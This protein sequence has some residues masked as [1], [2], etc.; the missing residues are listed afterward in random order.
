M[1][2][3]V[4]RLYPSP[5]NF[6]AFEFAEDEFFPEG[7]T[8]NGDTLYISSLKSG[9]IRTLNVN[10]GEVDTLVAAGVDGIGS[11]WGLTFD[12]ANNLLLACGNGPFGQ[13]AGSDG[14][15]AVRAF[16]PNTGVMVKKWSLPQG[17]VCNMVALDIDGNLYIADVG[18]PRVV[19]VDRRTDD[20]SVW[21][22]DS[23]WQSDTGFFLAGIANDGAGNF[24]VHDASN[25]VYRIPV[26]R[27][28]AAG[29]PI[30]QTVQDADGNPFALIGVDGLAFAGASASGA[31]KGAL[32]TTNTD[33]QSGLGDIVRLEIQENDVLV[34]QRVVHDLQVPASIFV[35]GKTVYTS[36]LQALALLN[37]TAPQTPFRVL[38]FELQ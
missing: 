38:R 5:P 21:V 1:S 29:T 12:R 17:G 26:G 3:I 8:V 10:S 32:L 2:L 13:P 35:D 31:D 11:S 19:R 18:A 14:V 23:R 25:T 9:E 27:D 6:T 4:S 28:G 24:Y 37:G 16:E 33:F 15:N 22:E 30:A 36:E 20:V 7:I 34:A